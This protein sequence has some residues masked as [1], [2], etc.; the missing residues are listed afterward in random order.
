MTARLSP[1]RRHAMIALLGVISVTGYTATHAP[2][3][4]ELSHAAVANV[5]DIERQELN[6]SERL[7]MPTKI[8]AVGDHVVVIDAVSDAAL[9]VINRMDGEWIRSF[10]G[11]GEGPGEFTSAW[12]LDPVAGSTSELWVFDAGLRRISYVD[13]SDAFF[14]EGRLGEKSVNLISNATIT[15]I[16]RTDQGRFVGPGFFEAGRLAV[17][18]ESGSQVATVGSIPAA[19]IVMPAALRQRMHFGTVT[20]HPEHRLV[21]L[22]SRYAS[23]IE[24]LRADG[25]LVGLADVPIEVTPDAGSV[26]PR[27]G[28]VA[29][30]STRYAYIDIAAS[31]DL[32]FALFSGRTAAGYPDRD[33]F[34]RYVHVFDWDGEFRGAIRLEVDAVALTVDQNSSAIY[35]VE[36]DPLPAIAAYSLAGFFG[37]PAP[38]LADQGL[39]KRTAG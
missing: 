34:A 23:R 39:R 14:E 37:G 7:G 31:R 33:N 17:F 16:I 30:E 5:V 22:A 27:R 19:N 11:R 12:S 32:V 4:T 13:L 2:S 35:V 18:D 38:V 28:V 1:A 8:A 36:H 26:D 29:D 3:E 24:I 10:G 21:A 9:H 20:A 15:G 6:S 25:S